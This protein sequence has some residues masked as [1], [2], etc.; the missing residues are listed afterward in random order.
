MKQAKAV[1]AIGVTFL[2]ALVEYLA[3]AL[4]KELIVS[5]GVF[6]SGMAVYFIPNKI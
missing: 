1:V 5:G 2:I 3:P 4:P 6:L